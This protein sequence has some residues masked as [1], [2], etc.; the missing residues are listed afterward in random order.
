MSAHLTVVT[1]HNTKLPGHRSTNK[2]KAISLN[3]PS[4]QRD[5]CGYRDHRERS[6][7]RDR[8]PVLAKRNEP[9]I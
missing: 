8:C 5:R 1:P 9:K 2:G 4:Y 7:P 3:D 6:D